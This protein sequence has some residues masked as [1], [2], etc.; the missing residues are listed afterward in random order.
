MGEF[1]TSLWLLLG[2]NRQIIKSLL[3]NSKHGLF[4]LRISTIENTNSM[5]FLRAKEGFIPYQTG[6]F[7]CLSEV[8]CFISEGTNRPASHA[9]VKNNSTCTYKKGSISKR[10]HKIFFVKLFFYGEL[11]KEARQ[12]SGIK[13]NNKN[14][15][16]FA[17][18]PIHLKLFC[19]VVSRFM[20]WQNSHGANRLTSGWNNF[21]G[22]DVRAKRPVTNTLPY[23]ETFWWWV[24]ADKKFYERNIRY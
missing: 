3:F 4:T 10:K 22:I 1:W 23:L 21:G 13:E 16:R 20:R 12:K 5:I 24:M 6:Y 2:N 11:I 18:R 7:L 15:G 8:W 17:R 14:Y 19:L 9:S